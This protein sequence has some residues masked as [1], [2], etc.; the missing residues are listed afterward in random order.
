MPIELSQ[1]R[2]RLI[3][4]MSIAARV[5]VA[6]AVSG[7]GAGEL[8]EAADDATWSDA[9]PHQVAFVEAAPD[10]RLEVLDWGGTGPALVFLPGLGNTAHAFDDFAPRLV[11]QFHVLAI[12]RRG[13]GASSHPDSGYDGNTLAAD[14]LGVL[15]SLQIDRAIVAGHSIAAM[16]LT[17]LGTEHPDRIRQLVYLDTSCLMPETDSL[18]FAPPPPGMPTPPAPADADT[19]TAAGYVDFVHRTR[20]VNIPEADIRARYTTDGWDE[21]RGSGYRPVL[22]AFRRQKPACQGV[23]VPVFAILA[24]RTT[25]AEEE[26]WVRVDSAGWPATQ[27]MA[28]RG[29]EVT[30]RIV[31]E[32]P[33]V[34]P[35]SRVDL[36][37]GGHHWIFVSH[38]DEVERLM[39]AVLR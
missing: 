26:P 8:A 15:D 23:Q 35:S 37:A 32:L 1:G 36:I 30:R 34:I 14:V 2:R 39:R 29:A 11:D 16:E 19:L 10:V 6:V 25:I 20:G 22:E 17:A 28:T 9:S 33:V 18:L 7:C 21:G 3:R 4:P 38:P 12:T 5:V 24:S 13:F 27:V 31:A